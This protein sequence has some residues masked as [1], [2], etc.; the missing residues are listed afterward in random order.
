MHSNETL[1]YEYKFTATNALVMVMSAFAVTVACGYIAYTNP[2]SSFSRLADKLGLQ[3]VLP[4]F[5]WALTFAC[6]MATLLC[7]RIAFSATGSLSHVELGSDGIVVPEATV[8]MKPISIP[9]TS[10]TNIQ[11]NDIKGQQM[12]IISSNVGESRLFA[13]YF[14]APIDFTKFLMELDK[15]RQSK[16]LVVVTRSDPSQQSQ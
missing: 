9:Y 16:Y 8:S 1:R 14:H 10:I 15:R 5:F 12:A 11:L 4:I 7:L 2:E 6:T 13:K 3:N